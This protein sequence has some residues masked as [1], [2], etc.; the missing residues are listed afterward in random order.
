[1]LSATR[2]RAALASVFRAPISPVLSPAERTFPL[3]FKRT[4][5]RSDNSAARA[6][7]VSMTVSISLTCLSQLVVEFGVGAPAKSA[8]RSATESSR[9]R[10]RCSFSA[11]H[12][13]PFARERASILFEPSQ[14]VV[15]T[16]QMI[17]QL[18]L[19]LRQVLAGSADDGLRHPEP[20]GNLYRETP[21]GRSVQQPVCRRKRLGVE[22]E[23]RTS[24][25]FRRRGMRLQRVVMRG[26]DQMRAAAAK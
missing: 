6:F 1:M 2:S 9:V 7:S 23:G 20:R 18:L 5:A 14:V 21:S 11:P 4:A 13:R 19:R 3:A 25:A 26:C 12:Q 24:D 8:S 15:H 16:S 10:S 17:G 22:S